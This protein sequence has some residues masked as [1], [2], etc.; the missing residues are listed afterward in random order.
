MPS[1]VIWLILKATDWSVDI[2]FVTLATLS[3]EMWVIR[4]AGEIA[5]L[6]T[7]QRPLLVR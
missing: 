1:R 4:C 5:K 2:T 6:D 3:S 7:A